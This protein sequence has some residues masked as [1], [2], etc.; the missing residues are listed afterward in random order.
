MTNYSKNEKIE[1]L[2]KEGKWVEGTYK[3]P[4]DYEG[5]HIIL[6]FDIDYCHI[7]IPDD[8]IRKIFVS[9]CDETAHYRCE[10]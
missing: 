7:R 4:S 6:C 3:F 9:N 2:N 10:G 8:K 1:V 5:Q